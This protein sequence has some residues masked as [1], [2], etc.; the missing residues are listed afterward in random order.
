M[1]RFFVF[2]RRGCL[3]NMVGARVVIEVM[4]GVVVLV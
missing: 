4:V 1:S 3:G 2:F